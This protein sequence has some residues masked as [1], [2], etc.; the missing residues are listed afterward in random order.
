MHMQNFAEGGSSK[1]HE[2]DGYFLEAMRSSVLKCTP[3]KKDIVSR[4]KRKIK[5]DYC[6]FEM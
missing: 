4:R 5:Q 1:N 3:L 2:R 6:L